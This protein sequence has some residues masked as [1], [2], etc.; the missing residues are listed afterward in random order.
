M[1]VHSGG[2]VR[3]CRAPS[4]QRNYD[5]KAPVND[6]AIHPNQGELI[7]CDQMGGI[8]IL[9]LGENSCTHNLVK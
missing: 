8:I 2:N 7:S 5:H 6:V 9:D 3:F 4:V 1:L